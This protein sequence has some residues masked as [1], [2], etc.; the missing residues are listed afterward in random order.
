MNIFFHSDS[1]TWWQLD[2]LKWAVLF[3]G[4]SVGSLWPE[5]F[6]RYAIFLLIIGLL[7]SAYLGYVWLRSR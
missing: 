4:I 6:A 7:I 2:L 3:I 5:I 1:F